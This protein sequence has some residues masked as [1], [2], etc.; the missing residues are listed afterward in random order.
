[1]QQIDLVKND[2]KLL[3]KD[4]VLAVN[5]SI[6]LTT[7]SSAIYNGG[8]KEVKVILNVQVPEGFDETVLHKNP[9]DFVLASSK[10]LSLENS[11]FIGMITAADVRDFSLATK[12]D[13]EV[14]VSVIATAGVDHGESSGEDI[15]V[16]QIEGT[17][18]IIVIIDGNPTDSCL[19]SVLGTA[20]EAKSAGLKDLD[21]RSRYSGDSATGTITDSIV[22]AATKRGK[23]FNYAGPASKLGKLV[24]ACTR[25]AVKESLQKR[26]EYLPNRSFFNRL[27]ERHLSIERIAS[28]L[29]KVK[30]LDLEE[31]AIATTFARVLKQEPFLVAMLLAAA[32][33]DEDVKKGLLPPEMGVI[34]AASK[35][36]GEMLNRTFIKGK[37][38]PNR[39]K[40]GEKNV[41]ADLSPFLK[42]VLI[43]IARNVLS[44]NNTE[45]L[46]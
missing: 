26:G 18:N 41:E 21:V 45:N 9:E 36:F 29:S 14:S 42:Q 5:S 40:K 25:E 7:V 44:R 33:L 28:E 31:R 10:K 12:S 27:E 11:Q 22:V 46:K 15:E 43:S 8:Y 4:N 35:D 23:K 37:A 2:I 13:G 6:N 30:G 39:D 34:D 16:E 24:G 20:T 17:I 19:V 32:K 38:H 3:L 1:M